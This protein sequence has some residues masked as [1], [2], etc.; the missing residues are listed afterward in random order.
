MGN[1]LVFSL[2]CHKN[3]LLLVHVENNRV[4]IPKNFGISSYDFT[5]SFGFNLITLF[6]VIV[7]GLYYYHLLY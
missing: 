5:L 2:N 3:N 1:I 4:F 7:L 6:I